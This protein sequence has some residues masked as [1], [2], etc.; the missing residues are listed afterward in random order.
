MKDH[1]DGGRG[2]GRDDGGGGDDGDVDDDDDDDVVDIVVDKYADE[3][4]QC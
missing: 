1:G 3:H 4:E 2:C